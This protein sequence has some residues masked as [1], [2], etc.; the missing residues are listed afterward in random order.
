[1]QPKMQR[2][3]LYSGCHSLLLAAKHDVVI[4]LEVFWRKEWKKLIVFFFFSREQNNVKKLFM[5]Q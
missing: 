4:K 2:T 3:K 5:R 1:M